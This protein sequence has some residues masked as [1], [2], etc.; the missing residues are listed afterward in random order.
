M[1]HDLMDVFM[2]VWADITSGRHAPLAFR[3]ILQP[4]V[5]A[6][7]AYRAGKRDAQAGRPYFF[8]EL[9][10]SPEHRTALFLEACRDIGK[11]AIVA[12]VMDCVYQYIENH[13]IYPGEAVIVAVILALLPYLVCRG[14]VNRVLRLTAHVP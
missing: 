5:A 8:E 12:A 13:W 11:V 6:F 9:V 1:L 4:A 14:I 7:F 10:T 2:R 3:F